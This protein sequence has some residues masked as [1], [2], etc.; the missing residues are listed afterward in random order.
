ME[1]LCH[2][3]HQQGMTAASSRVAGSDQELCG[4]MKYLLFMCV[5]KI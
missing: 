1:E 3:I 4:L 2:Y 5:W